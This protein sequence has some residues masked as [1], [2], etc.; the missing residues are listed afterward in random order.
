MPRTRRHFLVRSRS[1]LSSFEGTRSTFRSAFQPQPQLLL[2]VPDAPFDLA[3]LIFLLGQLAVLAFGSFPGVAR[4]ALLRQ[5]HEARKVLCPRLG[6]DFPEIILQIWKLTI[7]AGDGFDV[8]RHA[9]TQFGEPL[10]VSL[11]INRS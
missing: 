11:H 1:R 8:D 10:E 2:A 6:P 9:G 5:R 4:F 7:E 3:L